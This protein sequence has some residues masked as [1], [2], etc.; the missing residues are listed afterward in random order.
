MRL[1]KALVGMVVGLVVLLALAMFL[2]PTQRIAALVTGQF[3]LAT[4]RTLSIAGEVRPSFYPIIGAT[5]QD[6]TIGNPDW[7]GDV[8]FLQA[9]A[10]D[11]GLDVTA[12]WRGDIQIERVILQSPV[13]DLRRDAQ[14]RATWDVTVASAAASGAPE[15]GSATDAAAPRK[16]SLAMAEIRDGRLR[17]RDAG[18]DIDMTLSALDATLRLPD[19]TGPADL[20]LSGRLNDQPIAL[21]A[22]VANAMQLAA[23]TVTPVTLD[24]QLAGARVQ[25][26]GRAGLQNLSAEGALDLDLPALRPVLAALGQQGADIPTEYLPLSANLQLTRTSDGIIYARGATLRAGSIRATGAA[27]ITLSGARPRITGQFALGE[28]D[29]RSAGA[30]NGAAGGAGSSTAPAGWSRDTI[31]ASALSALDAVLD[32]TLDGLRTDLTALGRTRIGLSIDNARAVLDL[33]DVSLFGGAITGQLVANNRSGLS[34]RADVQARNVA[35]LPML[36]ELADFR[37]LQGTASLDVNLLGSGAS[38]HAIMNSLSGQGQLAFAQGQILGLDLGGML[39]NMDMS[40]MGE[41]QSTVYDS[42]T[43]SFSVTGGVLRNEDLRLSAPRFSVTGRGDVGVGARTLDY[44]VVPVALGSDGGDGFRVPLLITGP[45]DAPRF[46]LDLEALARERL[47]EEAARIEALARSEARR[48]E[49]RAKAEAAAKLEAELGVQRQEGE[50]LEDT[51]K[52]GLQDE[53]GRRL[54]G[55]LGGN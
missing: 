12:L 34:V 10:L 48:L 29:L 53:V 4:G 25:F 1:V 46:R 11:I 47:E 7:A 41:G 28:V 35:L 55:L 6:I 39:R 14:G 19:L 27:D 51:L 30:A 33:R 26:D 42:I 20:S 15:S 18:S 40:Y 54:Q 43:G 16:I 44:R 24:L 45:W 38:L 23:G 31:D 52:R 50:S 2:L 37:R 21:T 8:P 36:T 32:I 49:D 9:Q 22:S 5:A 3:Q 17:L 13:I